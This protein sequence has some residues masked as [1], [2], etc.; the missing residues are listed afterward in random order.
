[1]K[2][3]IDNTREQQNTTAPRI[4]K[5]PS[6][7]GTATI[8]DNRPAT[9]YQRKLQETMSTHTARKATPLQQKASPE[10]DRRANNTGLPDNLKTGMENLSGFSMDDVKVHYNSSKPAQLNAHAYAQGT[11]IYLG[12]GQEK[13]L[14]HELGHV[15]QQKTGGVKPTKLL[16][17]NV[18]VNDDVGLEKEA[19]VMGKS[20]LRNTAPKYT[21][22]K[23]PN[24]S[25][26]LIQ[27]AGGARNKGNRAKES[28]VQRVLNEETVQ[29]FMKKRDHIIDLIKAGTEA[30]LKEAEKLLYDKKKWLEEFEIIVEPKFTFLKTEEDLKTTASHFR[31]R[32]FW[33]HRST[34]RVEITAYHYFNQG[35][36]KSKF[37]Q[38]ITFWQ[39]VF[40]C[41][42]EEFMHWFQHKAG[43]YHSPSTNTFKKTEL[44]ENQK[45]ANYREVDIL[46]YYMDRGLDVEAVGYHEKY[47]ER[48]RYFTWRQDN[49][50][51]Q[52]DTL[53][54]RF[55][56]EVVKKYL[57]SYD[58]LTVLRH[59][60]DGLEAGSEIITIPKKYD[61]DP[62][63]ELIHTLLEHYG[64]KQGSDL[65]K[66]LMAA[67]GQN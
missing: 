26:Q 21:G 53:T 14:P 28:I 55:P 24:T 29:K 43:R 9:I 2:I 67:S 64:V 41:A 7:G 15:V 27:R 44:P 37:E 42:L 39:H 36:E 34:G 19:D 25:V 57:A 63:L 10:P 3:K 56:K 13:H 51:D 16:R 54:Y 30:H 61:Y 31:G 45:A 49:N 58:S 22:Y 32:G 65:H 12:P 20:A 48:K 40:M 8:V 47:D 6:T 33:Y 66:G 62:P 35:L 60:H 59:L 4:L 11:D 52:G 46:A 18:K 23:Q 38:D 1:M 17:G 5:E 50:F